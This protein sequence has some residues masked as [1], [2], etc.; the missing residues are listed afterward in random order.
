[1]LKLDKK[2]KKII[3]E[4]DVNS[5][6]PLSN[7][8]KK[9]SLKRESVLYRI[10]KYFEEGL[11]RNYLAVI[12]MSKLGFTHYKIYINLH[13][14]TEEQEKSMINWLCK[15]PFVSWI[16]NCD[17]AYSMIIAIK[18]R[19]SLEL[20]NILREINSKYGKFFKSQEIT[21]IICAHHFHR[22]YLVGYKGNTERKIEWGSESE[23]IELDDKNIELLDKLSEDPK[24]N[25]AE[26]ASKLKISPDSVIQRIKKL[27]NSKLI[28]NYTLWPNI[29]ELIGN[30][31][32][33]LISLKN[34]DSSSEKKLLSYILEN[35]NVIYC[36]NCIG[37]WNYEVDIEVEGINGL[38][39]I[40]R[41]L[42]NNFSDIISDY[43]S[44]NIYNE[45]KFR[46]FEKQIMRKEVKD[47]KEIN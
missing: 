42:V 17:G 9:V 18:S 15:N 39:K 38:R 4:L 41:E 33:V 46:F 34:F 21:T 32:K 23:K 26:I 29:N 7:I 8:A 10:K 2:D 1:M 37:K 27:E 31:Y 5:R 3:F 40:I 20:N 28:Q 47:N 11:L 6:Q 30:Y 36:V 43:T 35:P 22:D 12:D 13:N 25:A 44:L 14:I 19:N 24:A 45:Y 16:S